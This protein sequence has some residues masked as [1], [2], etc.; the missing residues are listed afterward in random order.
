M[1]GANADETMKHQAILVTIG[2][3]SPLE[4]YPAKQ[5]ARQVAQ[6][7]GVKDGLIYLPGA[8]TTYLE[9]SDQFL[10]FRQRR[11]FY[12]LSGVDEPDCHLTYDFRLDQLTLY[13]PE[14]NP[15]KVIWNGRGS[16]AEEALDKYD[17]DKVSCSSEVQDFVGEW[18]ATNKGDVYILHPD[19]A[20]EPGQDKSPRVNYTKLKVAI[21]TERVRKDPHEIKLIKH[22]NAVSAKAHRE[23]LASLSRFKNEAQVEASFLDT[24]IAE[25][26]KHQSYE[27][28]AASGENAATLH[29]V[30][31][32]EPFG[33][34]QL[35]CLDAGAEWQC[36]ASDVTRTFPLSGKWPS[37]EAKNIYYLVQ[38]MQ[39][40]CI[41]AIRPGV[42]FLDLHYM[43]HRIAIQGM[44]EL[45]IFHNGT[46]QEIFD[47]GTS[48]A[49][50]PHGLGHHLGLEVHDVS[51]VPLMTAENFALGLPVY[52]SECCKAP[53]HPYS[54]ALEEGMVITVEPGIYFSRYALK[55]L[56][57]TDPT[58]SKYINKEV[59]AKYLPV[60]G[61]R[62]ED[63]ILVTSNGYE[64]LTTAPK[65]EEML[66]IVNEGL[67]SNIHSNKEP[68]N[69]HLFQSVNH[70]SKKHTCDS[71]TILP[72]HG[73]RKRFYSVEDF[74]HPHEWERMAAQT[75]RRHVDERHVG[76]IHAPDLLPIH[77]DCHR[78]HEFLTA[79]S[80]S[81]TM[82][83]GHQITNNTQP[84]ELPENN[85]H[86]AGVQTGTKAKQGHWSK[87]PGA[88]ARYASSNNIRFHLDNNGGYN[89][90]GRVTGPDNG[91][92]PPSTFK[93]YPQLRF[94]GLED[95]CTRC[96]RQPPHKMGFC[97]YCLFV[98]GM[99]LTQ[100]ESP[101]DRKLLDKCENRWGPINPAVLEPQNQLHHITK[102]FKQ[103]DLPAKAP[104]LPSK[105]LA[106]HHSFQSLVL[107]HR[108][109]G[110]HERGLSNASFRTPSPASVDTPGAPN[111]WA[112]PAVSKFRRDRE[113][114][115]FGVDG[116]SHH[117]WTAAPQP[118]PNSTDD[119]RG[120]S[121]GG[122]PTSAYRGSY[123]G[124]YTY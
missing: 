49:V 50:F 14:I 103:P 7:L 57:F 24:C 72:S 101:E 106:Y 93:S 78:S 28:I 53:V 44:L 41:E 22:A 2:A 9:D 13:I 67:N 54:G 110:A 85:T 4:K 64:N 12:Y 55:K 104:E 10:P 5:H 46:K 47:A 116:N 17:I 62:I 60:G 27:I 109:L 16:T 98:I 11:Y 119:G 48:L 33:N 29:Y 23:V 108:H 63:D 32:D 117:N 90:A 99:D 1:V 42:R 56:Y 94:K 34:R 61:V 18:M 97:I 58:H 51:D 81:L 3:S 31:N 86:N 40:V 115:L 121:Y 114:T 73:Q 89:V 30:K 75:T 59:I 15:R 71:N 79:E 118:L 95:C 107:P 77:N 8:P 80:D 70:D 100:D 38:K 88:L 91:Y 6:R 92:K 45:G 113:I 123:A 120:N 21:D 37:E 65:G 52:D 76:D 25:D 66:R 36:Y 20:A 39:S 105:P 84:Q 68:G 43:A 124:P 87:V 102:P 122:C 96:T 111:P 83:D 69:G 35:M 112:D 82:K 19:Q 74:V 26:A